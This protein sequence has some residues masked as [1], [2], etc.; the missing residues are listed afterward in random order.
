VILNPSKF[1]FDPNQAELDAFVALVE[2][3]DQ[4]GNINIDDLG[5]IVD[6]TIANTDQAELQGIDFSITYAHD[7]NFGSMSYG[8]H[9][10]HQLDFILIQNGARIDQL[11]FQNDLTVSGNVAWQRDNMRAKLTLR[12]S[13]A[14]SANPAQAVNQT[15][16]DSFLVA[17]MVFGY[18]FEGSSTFTDGLSLRLNIDNIFDEDPPEYRVQRNLNYAHFTLGR[19]FKLGVTKKF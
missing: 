7:T 12:Y 16:V 13:D 15:S 8:L 19:V 10:N 5:L 2:N 4:F 11:E 17:D 3:S 9:G 6:R 18:D 14:F 1:V